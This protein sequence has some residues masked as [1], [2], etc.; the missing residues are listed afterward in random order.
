MDKDD[1]IHDRIINCVKY[2]GIYEAD[3]DLEYEESYYCFLFLKKTKPTK[4]THKSDMS[5]YNFGIYYFIIKKL[6]YLN[7]NIDLHTKYITKMKIKTLKLIIDILNNNYA[8]IRYNFT[9]EVVIKQY[10]WNSELIESIKNY[11]LFPYLERIHPK[12]IG[13]SYKK[14][15]ES[16]YIIYDEMRKLQ[17]AW[18]GVVAKASILH[19]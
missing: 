18:I 11:N 14:F 6:I 17:M 12:K 5:S 7:L 2:Y 1:V 19:K 9:I 8:N 3:S 10:H 13:F 16:A 15:E 4:I